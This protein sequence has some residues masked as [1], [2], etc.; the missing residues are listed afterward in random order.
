MVR[1]LLSNRE[2]RMLTLKDFKALLAKNDILLAEELA[3]GLEGSLRR[4]L[5]LA[6]HR[7]IV[8]DEIIKALE[9]RVAELES[10]VNNVTRISSKI[11]L[12]KS[13]RKVG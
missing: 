12:R 10:R 1:L 13:P 6:L 5:D 11:E 9:T 3:K 4:L 2:V 8:K 7:S